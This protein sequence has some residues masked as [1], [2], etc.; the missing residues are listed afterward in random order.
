MRRQPVFS[1][2]EGHFA[3][4]FLRVL[5]DRAYQSGEIP[6]LTDLQ[7]EA[8][9]TLEGLAEDASLHASFRQ[10][11]GDILLLNN[12]VTFHRRNEFEDYADPDHRRHD[13]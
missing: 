13:L 4:C 3:C 5:I 9:D 12:W 2:C 10:Q 8:L 11:P 6:P 1:F 7:R